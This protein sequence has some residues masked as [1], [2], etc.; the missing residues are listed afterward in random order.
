MSYHKKNA[1]H[2]ANR[3]QL[4]YNSIKSTYQLLVVV[5]SATWCGPCRAIEPVYRAM[6]EWFT[7][8]SF[9]KIDVDELPAI[10]ASVRSTWI[11]WKNASKIKLCIKAMSPSDFCLGPS[12]VLLCFMVDDY[13]V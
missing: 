7:D 11:C 5:F 13:G 1:F 4:R 9:A 6:A 2:S 3:W 8:V 12:V 10:S